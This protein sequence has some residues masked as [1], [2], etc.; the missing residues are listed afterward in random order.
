MKKELGSDTWK[1]LKNAPLRFHYALQDQMTNDMQT[2][3]EI[4]LCI[5]RLDDQRYAGQSE[6]LLCITRL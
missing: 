5:T 6:I 3:S 1:I 2:R 4:S